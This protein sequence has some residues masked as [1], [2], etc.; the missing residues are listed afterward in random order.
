MI[1]A[2]H[3]FALSTFALALAAALAPAT[4]AEPS[5]ATAAPAPAEPAAQA[6]RAV[7]DK[8]TGRLRAPNTEEMKEMIEAERAERK[9]RG[10]AEPSATK[11][12]IAIRTHANGMKSAVLGPDFHATLV[13]E[14]DADGKLRVKHLNPANEHAAPQ[15]KPA[16][17]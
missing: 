15:S 17:E 4:A 8:E 1:M 7:R 14:R 2:R 9:A 13:A 3:S 5:P 10:Q 12:P 6:L 16:T 11:T